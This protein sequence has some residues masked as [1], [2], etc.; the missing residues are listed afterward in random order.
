[1]PWPKTVPV[2]QRQLFV[3]EARRKTVPFAALCTLFGVSRKTGY[4]WLGRANVVGVGGLAD[5]SRRP[6]SNPMA[7]DQ[8]LVDRLVEL[9][10]EHPYWGGGKLLALVVT[11]EPWGVV[12]AGSTRTQILQRPGLVR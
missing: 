6:H 12:P 5:R 2:Q 9:R 8:V 7:I 4:K 10:R 1:M 11:H 3:Q